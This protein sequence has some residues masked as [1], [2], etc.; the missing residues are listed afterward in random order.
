MLKAFIFSYS[1]LLTLAASGLC[2]AQGINFSSSD[3][4]DEPVEVT[5]E[6]GF[7]L[8]QKEKRI[9]AYKN[10]AVKR[11]NA[12]LNADKMAADYRE[13]S[14]GSRELWRLNAVG[15]V[16]M[17]SEGRIVKGETAEY[18]LDNDSLTVYG[19]QASLDTDNEKIRADSL[20]YNQGKHLF[21]AKGK[22]AIIRDKGQVKADTIL[23][24][25]TENED[26]KLEINLMT[27][28]DN[29]IITTKEETATGDKAVYYPKSNEAVLTGNVK[30]TKG[31]NNL[32]GGEATVN[33]NTGISRIY[34]VDNNKEKSGSN[35]VNTTSTNSKGEPSK[36]NN[37]RVRGVFLP[38]SVKKSTNK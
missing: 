11:G 13:S 33:L 25:F 18:L 36:E 29:V 10:V 31:D 4:S 30:L 27:A 28:K 21:T 34:A 32:Q 19:K 22:A 6:D 1:F 20:E 23:I 14:D 12:T 35:A 15:N 7:E 9:Y 5:A 2:A 17:T 3:N 24:E 38:D 26:K 8:H 16:V 37:N